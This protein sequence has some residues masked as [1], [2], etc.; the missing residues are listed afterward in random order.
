VTAS[1]DKLIGGPQ[2]GLVLGTRECVARVRAH[3]LYRAMR[4]DKL[5]LIALEATL[6][7]FLDPAS[8]GRTHP[9]VSMLSADV[10]ELRR[11]AGILA[12][13]LRR[14]PEAEE[15]GL[16]VEVVDAADAVGAGSLPTVELPGA[17]VRV[18]LRDVEAGE[19]ARRL[20]AAPVPVFSTVKDGA[21]R[22]HVRTLLPGDDD[23][24]VAAVAAALG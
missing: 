3:P 12:D 10:A 2:A 24:V 15:S 1:G 16:S 5:R 4:C 21:V 14:V 19:L 6:R 22:L 20:R 17:A 18:G 7:L 8:L 13:R 23:D 9:T 11:R